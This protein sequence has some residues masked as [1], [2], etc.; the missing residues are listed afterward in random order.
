VV[1]LPYS[2]FGRIA[3]SDETFN[4]YLQH[5]LD[6]LEAEIRRAREE[7]GKQGPEHEGTRE[8]RS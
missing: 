3:V 4:E 5:E 8:R 2:H 6:N 1:I 7:L